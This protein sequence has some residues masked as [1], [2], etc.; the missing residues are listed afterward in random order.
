MSRPRVVLGVSGGIAAYKACELLRRFTESGHDVTVV[1]RD[2]TPGGRAGRLELGGYR[3][4][5]GPTVLTYYQALG[6][7]ADGDAEVPG[8]AAVCAQQLSVSMPGNDRLALSDVSL[9]VPIGSRTSAISC[10]AI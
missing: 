2:S 4:D 9:T 10:A 7:L 5:T 1:E 8:E 6:D 3:F